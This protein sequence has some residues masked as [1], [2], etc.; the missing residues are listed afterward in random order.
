MREAHTWI[1]R[2]QEMDA[3]QSSTN[4]SLQVEL[5]E[6]IEH[7]NQYWINIQRQVRLLM[8]CNFNDKK[9]NITL[10]V[11]DKFMIGYYTLFAR[12]L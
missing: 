6:R 7:F 8:L 3:L 10:F 12:W 2:V 11:C 9:K 4:Q 1:A 5:R